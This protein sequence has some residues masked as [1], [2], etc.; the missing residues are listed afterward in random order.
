[1]VIVDNYVD[2]TL[3]TLLTTLNQTVAVKVLTFSTPPDFALEA[4]KFIQQYDR[5][6]DVK[7]DRT[8]FH[9]RF[10]ILDGARVF[11]LG[12]S[13]KDAGSKAMM[14]HELEDQRNVLAVIQ[15]S[16]TA[17]NGADSVPL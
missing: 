1:M 16:Q 13:I 17:W 7:K 2:G 3:F 8:E 5:T 6:I 9:D 12:H 15:A 10:I 14:I 11:H 4:R